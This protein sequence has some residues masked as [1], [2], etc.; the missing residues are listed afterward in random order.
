M[1]SAS[2]SV[3]FAVIACSQD[4]GIAVPDQ[5]GEGEVL[6]GDAD[7][8]AGWL[9]GSARVDDG[10]TAVVGGK[11]Q[12]IARRREGNGVDPAGGIVQV[13]AADGVEG[14]SLAPGT[15]FWSLVDA[16]DEAG[17]DAGVGVCGASS[18]QDGVG[19][20]GEGGDGASNG[21]LEVLGDPPVILF[22][23]VAD[24]DDA[25]A[26][27][28]GELAFRGRP[29]DKGGGAIDAEKDE[30]WLPACWGGFPDVGVSV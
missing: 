14:Q 6:C 29:A 20:P 21:L 4:L 10:D 24:S 15:R 2:E 30:S 8:C 5:A 28:D 17:K 25:G 7:H 11:S 18:E 13:F 3:R 16:F 1:L 26:G 19:V 12:G 23:E 22:F 27:A 9:L